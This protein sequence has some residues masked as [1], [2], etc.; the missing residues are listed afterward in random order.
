MSWQVLRAGSASDARLACGHLDNL[1]FAQRVVD[2]AG[3][4]LSRE[5]LATARSSVTVLVREGDILAA[6]ELLADATPA[7]RTSRVD[8][9]VGRLGV[10]IRACG[11]TPFAVIGLCLAPYYLSRAR[12]SAFPPR[13]HA[14][15]VA[16]IV[17][18]GLTTAIY[19]GLFAITAR[20]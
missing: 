1:G 4:F 6:N 13:E 14:W 2:V 12:K 15:N 3:K 8:R 9:S 18:C 11:L 16:G 10:S 19:I 5:E 20:S 17:V 7:P